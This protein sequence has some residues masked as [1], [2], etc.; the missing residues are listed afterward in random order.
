MITIALIG[1][2]NVGKSS[3]FNALAGKQLA[4]VHDTPGLTRDYRLAEGSLQDRR[5]NIMDTAGLENVKGDDVVRRQMQEK[6]RAA[7]MKSD[8][9]L[10]VID[11]QEGITEIDRQM[12][13]DI[14]KW[15]KPIVLLVNKSDTK[16]SRETAVDALAFGFGEPVMI[17]AA[18]NDGFYDLY[19]ALEK[20]FPEEE[21]IE[22]VEDEQD[23]FIEIEEGADLDN[24]EI[25]EEVEDPDKP[26]KIA[27]VGRPNVGKSTLL[28]AI[29]GEER[30][31]TSPVAGTTRDSVS[32][33]WIFDDRRFRLVDTAGLRKRHKIVDRIEK[34][35]AVET[36]RAIRLAHVVIL[37]LDATQEFEHQDQSI[38]A[39]VVDE[40]R[41]L[42]VAVNKWDEVADGEAKRKELRERLG[43]DISQVKDVPMVTLSA[44]KGKGVDKLLSMVIDTY[45]IWNRRVATAPLNRFLARME[46]AHQPPMASGRSNRLRYMTQIKARP[47]TFALWVSRPGDLPDS[48]QRYLVNGL[49]EEFNFPGVPIRFSLRKSKNPYTDK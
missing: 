5:F 30:A 43:F 46:S 32:V 10:F 23:A 34:M 48:Y 11:G 33:D 39:H 29:I 20:Y 19:D 31:I 27:I 7:V 42:I 6:T 38:A 25:P 14:R 8:V 40:G 21:A 22:T 41:A 28:N 15:N 36:Q 4:L 16:K 47:P 49:R 13:R 44:L 17:S 3:L 1:R 2:P 26:I 45:G 24:E 35:S 18:H 37:V 9:L 12:A